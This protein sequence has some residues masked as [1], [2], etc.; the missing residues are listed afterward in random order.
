MRYKFVALI[1]ALGAALFVG[2]APSDKSPDQPTVRSFGAIGDGEA[3]DSDA[4][5]K[6]V[7][8]SIGQIRFPKGTFRITKTITI[9]LDRVGPTSLTSDGTAT[10]VMAGPGPAFRFVGTHD[11]TASPRTVK[12][13]VWSRQRTPMVD[14]IEI[15]GDHDKACGIEAT[16]TMQIT[17]TR[18]VVREALHGIHLVQR[19]RN[20]I[21]S[22]CHLYDNRGIGVFLDKLNLHQIN[23]I[24]SHIS[25]NDGGGVVSRNSEIRN[26][27]IG[28]CDIEGNM[29]GPESEPTANVLLD[30]TDSSLGE[31][32]IVGCTIQHSH[33]APN[34][35]NI[36][37]NC[38][39][40]ERSV[41]DELRHG[42]ITISDN[43]L[44]D[45]RV[46]VD[47]QNARGVTISGNTMWK[48]YDRNLIVDGC[49][50]VVVTGNVFDRNPRYHYSDGSDAKLGVLFR[51]TTDCTITGNHINGVG[52]IPAAMTLER[53]Q[54]MNIDACTINEFGKCGILLKDVSES[55]ISDCLIRDKV[56]GAVSIVVESGK[57]NVIVDNFLVQRPSVKPGTAYASGNVATN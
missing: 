26:L 35:G 11:G 47:L 16:G 51:D 18:T 39:S 20:V 7:D 40:T 28:T 42:N 45:V 3:D 24:G 41:T 13:N 5:Q 8:S 17:I 10:I 1:V 15:V 22:D 14:G 33:D 49:K 53:C 23:I 9:D 56:D 31:V 52:D 55:R 4:I 21:V 32:S 12:P 48:G 37:I 25:Y 57:D 29:G 44:S 54:R 38:K 46:N 19:N 50:N 6:A 30:A 36:R 2:L 43:V 27:Q 34:S